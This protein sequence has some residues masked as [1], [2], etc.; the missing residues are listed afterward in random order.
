MSENT[1]QEQSK[2]WVPETAQS[3]PPL[4]PV[5]TTKPQKNPKRVEA[6]KKLAAHN[7]Q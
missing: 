2:P 6:G 7:K 4:Q 1:Q 5:A 3:L